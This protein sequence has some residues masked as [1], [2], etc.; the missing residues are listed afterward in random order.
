MSHA[1]DRTLPATPRRREAA[2][3][4]GAMPTAAAPAWAA[5]AA[6]T[7]LLG[8]AWLRATV[9]AGAD[10]LRATLPA[11]GPPEF[12]TLLPAALVLPT[13]GL[14]LAAGTAGLAVRLLLDGFTLQPG[15]AAPDPRRIDPCAGLARILSLRTLGAALGAGI[16]LALLAAAALRAGTPLVSLAASGDALDDPGRLVTAA[17]RPLA[18]LVVAAA[19]VSVVQWALARRRFEATIRMTPQEFADEARGMQADPKVRLLHARRARPG[20]AAGDGAGAGAGA[21]ARS[22]AR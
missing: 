11:A 4:A 17:W 19:V 3:R 14:V 15:R 5:T 1:S 16:G 20:H 21:G 12:A 6:T 9:P 18:W 8:P 13:V 22:G 7:V 2:R 10:L